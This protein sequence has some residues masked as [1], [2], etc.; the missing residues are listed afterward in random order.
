MK[1]WKFVSLVIILSMVLPTMTY[2]LN[3]TPSSSGTPQNSTGQMLYISASSSGVVPPS[4]PATG[5]IN[6]STQMNVMVSL[7]FRNQAKL[8]NLINELQNTS[9]PNYHRY[10][11][12]GQ[13]VSEFSP[14]ANEYSSYVRYFES[15]G[16]SIAG[17]YPDR[18]SIVLKGTAFQF[19]NIFHTRIMDFNINSRNFYGP[20]SNLSLSVNFGPISG[21]VGLS[22]QFKPQVSPLFTGSGNNS[23]GI[24]RSCLPGRLSKY[25][26]HP[27]L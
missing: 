16:L 18:I 13:F 19:E 17:T 6:A 4:I 20:D 10:L 27:S 23:I 24:G 2:L 22:D 25:R 8:N 3:Y 15:K 5:V 9:S 11:T 1:L 14:S 7:N 12:S 21:V 26:T